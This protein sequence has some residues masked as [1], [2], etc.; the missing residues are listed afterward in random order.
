MPRGGKRPGTGGSHGGGRP[1]E[2]E[3][4]VRFYVT[5]ERA[6]REALDAYAERHRISRA[7]AVR[8][9]VRLLTDEGHNDDE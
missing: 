5:L 4:P 1:K 2:L 9:A 7:E 3:E 8:R 6:D